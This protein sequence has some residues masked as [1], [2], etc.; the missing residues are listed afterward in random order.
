MTIPRTDIRKAVVAAVTGLSTT[1]SAVVESR[2]YE[3]KRTPELA[4]FTPTDR[5]NDEE[6][7][8]DNDA[9]VVT[10]IVE[11]RAKAN[12]ALEDALDTICGEVVA[13]L[14]AD[15]T[16]N[17]TCDDLE[18]DVFDSELSGQA[19]KPFGLGT[20]EF[21]AFYRTLHGAPNTKL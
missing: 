21:S 9:R 19:E 14:M 4:V 2:V 17:G 13:A 7:T 16:L 20:L 12:S 3:R 11:I 5:R 6:V 10:I 8:M 1:G 18:F 15:T